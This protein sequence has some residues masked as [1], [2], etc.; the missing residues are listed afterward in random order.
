MKKNL[1]TAV[2]GFTAMLFISASLLITGCSKDNTS[3]AERKSSGT[4]VIPVVK[5]DSCDLKTFTQGGWGS[6]PH[7]NN[8]GTYQFKNFA[9]AFPSG[10]TV[11]CSTGYTIKLTSAQAV[12]N[13]LPCGGSAAALTANY[14]D[15]TTVKNV[16]AGQLVALSLSVGFDNHDP[17]FAGS[18]LHLG[19][20]TIKS[21]TF[22]GMTVNQVIA[23][24]NKALGGCATN[25]SISD[26]N[27]I[28]TAINENFDNGTVNNGILNCKEGDIIPW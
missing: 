27:S 1:Q 26:L 11:G 12:C 10:L 23:E 19:N 18:P 7:G 2:T 21:G 5:G 4:V 24:A 6:N 17:N 8:P 13:F 28:L 20:L 15:P 25:Y 9:A 22:Q 16:L 3:S 14:T